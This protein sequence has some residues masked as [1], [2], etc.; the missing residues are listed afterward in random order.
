MKIFRNKF[1]NSI[2]FIKLI[3][4]FCLSPIIQDKYFN[5]FFIYFLNN[6]SLDVWSNFLL[7]NGDPLSFPYGPIM[8]M[9]FLPLTYLGHIL[10]SYIGFETY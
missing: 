3:A 10:G 8:F 5:T 6:P 2:L 7:E 1:F 9:V 4:I